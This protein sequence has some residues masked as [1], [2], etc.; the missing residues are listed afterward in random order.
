MPP[1]LALIICIFFIV[2]L[3]RIDLKKSNG[4]PIAL[5]VPLVWMFLAGS[6]YASSW[7]NLGAP[8]AS[9]DDYSEGSPVDR[10]VFFSLIGV[11]AFLLSRRKIDWGR[12]RSQNKWIV[13]YFLYCLSSI[14]WTDEPF[15]LF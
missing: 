12:L 2:C 14:A 4:P 8:L 9:V 3:F 11:G 10:A 5:W 13:F 15:V 1:Q 7:L 6:R